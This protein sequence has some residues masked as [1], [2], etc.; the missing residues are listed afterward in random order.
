MRL[1]FTMTSDNVE[2]METCRKLFSYKE[3]LVSLHPDLKDEKKATLSIERH[4]PASD[5]DQTLS[6]NKRLQKEGCLKNESDI[7]AFE[8]IK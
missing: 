6:L 5:L 8:A 3:D 7:F 4:F 2:L 1:K